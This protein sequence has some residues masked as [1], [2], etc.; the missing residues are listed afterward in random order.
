MPNAAPSSEHWNVEPASVDVYVN[1]ADVE[2]K[3][4]LGP[5]VMV[6]SGGAVLTMNVRVVT[7]GFG[8]AASAA[9]TENVYG[10]SARSAYG[11]AFDL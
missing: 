5:P 8:N 4:P 3:E 9:R 1:A 6:V 10:P 7:G 2:L 11:C